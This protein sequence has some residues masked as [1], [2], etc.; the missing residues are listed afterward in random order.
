MEGWLL[1]YEKVP[2]PAPFLVLQAMA[3]AELSICTQPLEGAFLILA[4]IAPA[5]VTFSVVSGLT[6]STG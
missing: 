6:T 5:D 2:F 1:G 3:P 4:T